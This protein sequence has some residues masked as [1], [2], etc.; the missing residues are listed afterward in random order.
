MFQGGRYE[1]EFED[2]DVS[3]TVQKVT[4]S[5]VPLEN[6]LSDSP[7]T[8]C[9]RGYQQKQRLSSPPATSRRRI[10]K[11]QRVLPPSRLPLD[12]D[13]AGECEN[14]AA[15]QQQQQKTSTADKCRP[16]LCAV[17][18]ESW[19]NRKRKCDCGA[20]NIW[21]EALMD[22]SASHLMTAAAADHN[23]TEGA[24]A[25]VPVGGTK[26]ITPVADDEG[27]A[28]AEDWCF[29]GNTATV[30][31]AAQVDNNAT[32]STLNTASAIASDGD[33]AVVSSVVAAGLVQLL[34]RVLEQFREC[35][36]EA[37]SSEAVRVKLAKVWAHTLRASTAMSHNNT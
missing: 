36:S 26:Q 33:Q 14:G 2:G 20:D 34:H 18:G 13:T 25:L 22:V 4:S 16:K 12:L 17:C 27:G 24:A 15:Q 3:Q 30:S 29:L 32:D 1:V 10:S 5:L 35:Y 7:E 21:D 11:K 6:N 19:G 28:A 9:R 23:W 8:P 31:V 37:V